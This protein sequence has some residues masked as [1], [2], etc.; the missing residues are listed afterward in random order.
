M[1]NVEPDHGLGLPTRA[2]VSLTPSPLTLM[3][4]GPP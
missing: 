3:W 2:R 1:R 4:K